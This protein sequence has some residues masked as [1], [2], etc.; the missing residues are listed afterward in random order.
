MLLGSTKGEKLRNLPAY[1]QQQNS[2]EYLGNHGL[3]FKYLPAFLK[4]GKVTKIVI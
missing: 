1:W 4:V 2:N 3:K